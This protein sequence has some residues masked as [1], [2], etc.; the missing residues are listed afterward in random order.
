[1]ALKKTA[2]SRADSNALIVRIVSENTVREYKRKQ[3]VFSQGDPAKAVFYIL[4][5]KI[6]ATVISKQG[7]Q[8]AFS[9]L[10][11]GS[12]FGERCLTGQP[13]RLYTAI[14]TEQST[15]VRIEKKRMVVLLREEPKFSDRFMT[16]L[17]LHCGRLEEDLVDH[18][19]NSS[20]KRLARI[21]L[22]LAH[23]GENGSFEHVIPKISQESLAEMVGTTRP[24]VSFFMKRFKK[25]GF[26]HDNDGL[27]VHSS[28]L[29]IILHD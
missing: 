10:E 24:R 12:F 22:L 27:V 1:M 17:L 14:A 3:I 4:E 23:V 25:L 13:L 15:I 7:K 2:P 28:L 20:E 9:I 6:K 5:G 18:L 8:A 11:N 16:Y 21:L 29:N 19:F 26:I